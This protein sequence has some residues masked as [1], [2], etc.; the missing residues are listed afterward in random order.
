MK[1]HILIII[2]EENYFLPLGL[3]STN[4]KT[5]NIDNIYR[6]YRNI[7]IISVNYGNIFS[8]P[9]IRCQ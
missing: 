9:S 7:I 4:R 2:I 3:Q 6:K 5:S 1:R 8:I